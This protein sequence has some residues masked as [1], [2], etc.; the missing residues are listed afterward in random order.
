MGAL[1]H[2]LLALLAC[3]GLACTGA[4]G[5]AAVPPATAH[6]IDQTGSLDAVQAGTLETRLS[7]F[8]REHGTQVVV[9]I[10]PTTAPETIEQ[11]GIRVADQWRIGRKGVDDGVIVLVALKD[12]AARIE[13]GYGLEGVLTD[14]AS[15]RILAE[16]MAPKLRAGDIAGGVSDGVDRILSTL[17]AAAGS[18][19]VSSPG[20]A[21]P[22]REQI[23]DFSPYFWV[24]VVAIALGGLL[25]RAFGP[26]KAAALTAPV[27]AFLGW[28]AGGSV[29]VILGAAALAAVLAALG[30]SAWL[31][32]GG[33]GGGGSSFKGR[34][35][36]FG[37]GGASGRW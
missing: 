10:V 19:S 7:A 36:G 37:G 33:G 1:R 18:S 3:A 9:L 4:W 34:G 28:L 22:P 24:V 13:V 29:V 21:A 23:G 35:G 16:A 11:F 32:W 27:G 17:S 30:I 2:I 5:Q 6:V 14:A 12:R 25:R 15:H 26:L 20:R 31:P 8:E